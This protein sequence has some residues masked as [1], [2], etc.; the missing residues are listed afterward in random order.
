MFLV[1]GVMKDLR[2]N[3]AFINIEILSHVEN[4]FGQKNEKE[5]NTKKTINKTKQN[6][7]KNKAKETKF[8][9]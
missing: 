1:P 6:K 9:Y 3:F 7:N 4:S 8:R 5:K 2:L